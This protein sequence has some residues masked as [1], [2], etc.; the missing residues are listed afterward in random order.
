MEE[1]LVKYKKEYVRMQFHKM[2]IQRIKFMVN[3]YLKLLLSQIQKNMFNIIQT[4]T[5]GPALDSAVF[6]G[7]K[8]SAAGVDILVEMTV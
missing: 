5:R 7:V 8:K 1:N 3:S 2:E 6:V 4:A